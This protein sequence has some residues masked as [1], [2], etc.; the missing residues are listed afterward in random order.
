MHAKYFLLIFIANLLTISRVGFWCVL[1]YKQ[2]A[3]FKVWQK[4]EEYSF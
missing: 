1:S 3:D 4:K 2:A